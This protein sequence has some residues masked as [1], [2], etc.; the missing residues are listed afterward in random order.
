MRDA[1]LHLLAVLGVWKVIEVLAARHRRRLSYSG[2]VNVLSNGMVLPDP[3]D[4]EWKLVVEASVPGVLLSIRGNVSGVTVHW[5]E[6]GFHALWLGGVREQG[7]LANRY[8]LAV[9]AEYKR[10]AA[11]RF[12]G[13]TS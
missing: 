12:L 2:P 7:P 4:P 6:S 13:P 8:V 5:M 1:V 10:R 11:E 3:D 9:V